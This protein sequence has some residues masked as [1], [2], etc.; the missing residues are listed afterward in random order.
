MII[1]DYLFFIKMTEV[2]IEN[3]TN[4][5][6]TAVTVVQLHFQEKNPL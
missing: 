5:P 6:P 4:E 3:K 2:I 1:L